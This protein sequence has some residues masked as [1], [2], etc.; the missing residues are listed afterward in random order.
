MVNCFCIYRCGLY[1][2]PQNMCLGSYIR[3]VLS[4]GQCLGWPF[5]MGYYRVI[6]QDVNQYKFTFWANNDEFEDDQWTRSLRKESGA[7]IILKDSRKV[8]LS[9]SRPWKNLVL[10]QIPRVWNILARAVQTSI[11]F[12]VEPLRD[13]TRPYPNFC[14]FGWR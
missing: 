3:I 14:K 5:K 2:G 6:H 1:N 4:M 13:S 12:R 7:K 9:L 11:H 10:A 8:F